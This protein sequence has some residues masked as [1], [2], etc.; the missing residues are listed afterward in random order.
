M[1]NT[2]AAPEAPPPAHAARRQRPRAVAD[3]RRALVLDAAREAFFEL[4]LEGAS[5]REIAKRAGYSPGA[6]YSYFASKE[7]VYAALLGESL[8]RLHARVATAT[9]AS[10]AEP[11]RITRSPARSSAAR[12]RSSLVVAAGSTS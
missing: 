5:L 12:L 2:L 3:V 1:E 4:G 11:Q 7:E 8:E 10:P 9:A 6:L